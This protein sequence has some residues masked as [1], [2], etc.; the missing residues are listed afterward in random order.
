MTSISTLSAAAVSSRPP[1]NRLWCGAALA[2]ALA[3]G[4]AAQAQTSPSEAAVS[5]ATV[6]YA[7]LERGDLTAAITAARQAVGQ[8]PDWL[9]YRLLL[10]DALL[11]A[12]RNVEAYAALAPAQSQPDYRVQSRLAQAAAG[13]GLKSEAAEA[14]GAAAATAPDG[15]SRAYLTR[16]RIMTL[17]ELNDAAG[18]RQA[19]DRAWASGTLTG[20]APID[21]AMLAIAVG[22]DDAAQSAFADAERSQGLT[23]RVALDAGYSARRVGRNADAVRYFNRGLQDARSGQFELSAQQA[24]EIRQ[25]IAAL[26][27]QGG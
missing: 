11:R 3:A 1:V 27:G 4:G 6:G 24:S 9:D 5:A 21:A 2:L 7:Q 13:A 15:E 25:E 8:A 14:F 20:Y 10:A 26:G 16:A 18:A 17:L 12:G 22:D 23:G 19:F